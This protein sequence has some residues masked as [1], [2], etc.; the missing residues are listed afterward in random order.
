MGCMRKRKKLKQLSGNIPA[1]FILDGTTNKLSK[2][3]WQIYAQLL[4]R[5]NFKTHITDIRFSYLKKLVPSNGEEIANS[6]KHLQNLGVISIKKRFSVDATGD[7]I[8]THIYELHG[9]D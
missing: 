1:K 8:T 4:L 2:K 9:Y 6:L 3:D 5:Q 7:P